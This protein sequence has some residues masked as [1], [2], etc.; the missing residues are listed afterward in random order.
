ME[1]NKERNKGTKM[2][3]N[4]IIKFLIL[5]GRKKWMNELKI[6]L[7]QWWNGKKQ[8]N[9]IKSNQIKSKKSYEEEF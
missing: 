7:K 3:F 2:N 8:R 5:I 1:E 4:E 9:Q 6:W